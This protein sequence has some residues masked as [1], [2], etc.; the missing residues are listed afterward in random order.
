MECFY[1]MVYLCT[2]VT[3]MFKSSITHCVAKRQFRHTY[4]RTS[5]KQI[6]LNIVEF[7]K[8]VT[9]YYIVVNNSLWMHIVLF[10]NKTSFSKFI[11]K[12][13][14]VFKVYLI[15]V[16]YGLNVKKPS[17]ILL[18]AM[19]FLTTTFETPPFLLQNDAFSSYVNFFRYI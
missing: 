16:S 10:S 6:L 9:F 7:F 19:N 14:I 11:F 13:S 4:N 8:F 2:D 15:N 3:N 5:L 1:I 18:K 12:D 17:D